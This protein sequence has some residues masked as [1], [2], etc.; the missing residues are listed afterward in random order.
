M[1]IDLWGSFNFH[2]FRDF[3]LKASI[4]VLNVGAPNMTSINPKR[5]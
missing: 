1:F 5:H 3:Q 4:E 2:M